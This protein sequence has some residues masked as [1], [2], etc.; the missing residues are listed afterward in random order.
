MASESAPVL[1]TEANTAQ[2]ELRNETKPAEDTAA[3][4]AEQEADKPAG[5]A[6]EE[7]PGDG[8]SS[9]PDE[10]Q[11]GTEGPLL[12]DKRS[13]D[14][15]EPTPSASNTGLKKQKTEDDAVEQPETAKATSTTDNAGPSTNGQKKK[16]GRPKKGT[17][18]NP[19]KKIPPRPTEGIGSRT[20]S[21]SKPMN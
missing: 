18:A 10:S 15:A 2:S 20:R 9:K 17:I 12:G 11:N 7:A 8:S 16:A 14:E 21:R 19:V 1:V 6:N 4:D 13:L 3:K 5:S